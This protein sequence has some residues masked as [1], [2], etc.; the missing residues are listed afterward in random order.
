MSL[1]SITSAKLSFVA[2]ITIGTP[3]NYSEF[4]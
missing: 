1:F 2:S 4:H 3:R